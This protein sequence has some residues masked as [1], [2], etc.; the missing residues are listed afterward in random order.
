MAGFQKAVREQIWTK[1]LLGG[2]SG[3]GKSYG[4]LLLA[5]G[6]VSKT[7]GRIAYIG[8]EGSRDKYYSDE[9][10]YDLLQL[11]DPFTPEKYIEAID[12][13][14]NGGYKVLII[15]SISHEWKTLN[16]IHD[17]MPGNSFTNWGKLKSRHRAFQE[18][19]LYSPIHV[20][21]TGRGK[22]E[23]VLEEKNGKQVPKKVGM[24]LVADKEI[25]FDYT[26]SL[27]I[28]QDNHIASADK[29]NTHIWDGRYEVITE[30]DGVRLFNW[31]NTGEAP[32][33]M[34][35]MSSSVEGSQAA[36]DL[37]SVIDQIIAI[38]KSAGGSTNDELMT[39]VREYAP[40]GNP[41]VI[42]DIEKAKELLTRLQEFSK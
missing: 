12:Q 33:V 41:H 5:K 22:D 27:T 10:D 26:L 39:I 15:D 28:Q 9:F 32:A 35:K 2:P 20:I 14:I 24:G 6:L 37:K 30:N 7:G 3:C 31:A 1:T 19:V 42:K 16:D 36:D 40:K 11:E 21:S 38:A 4:A 34:P 25:S 8:T 18:K 17:K 23:W 29:D 13:A